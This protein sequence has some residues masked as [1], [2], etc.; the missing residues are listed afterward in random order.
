MKLEIKA[1]R[2][3][4]IHKYMEIKQHNPKEPIYQRRNQEGNFK[5]S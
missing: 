3:L 2:K 4:D 5:I 1:E